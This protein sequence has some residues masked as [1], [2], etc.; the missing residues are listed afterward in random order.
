MMLWALA[1]YEKTVGY[2]RHDE[3]KH[4]LVAMAA[5]LGLLPADQEQSPR[6]PLRPLQAGEDEQDENKDG[7]ED[8]EEVEGRQPPPQHASTNWICTKIMTTDVQAKLR[9]FSLSRCAMPELIVMIRPSLPRPPAGGPGGPELALDEYAAQS[10]LPGAACS[11]LQKS[12]DM[13]QK[14][15]VKKKHILVVN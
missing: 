1:Y 3:I 5:F 4:G 7:K 10:T 12:C 8:G 15:T 6:D 14:V 13:T 9:H 11:M 2:L